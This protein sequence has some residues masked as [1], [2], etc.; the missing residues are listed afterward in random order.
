MVSYASGYKID[1]VNKKITQTGMIDIKTDP[2]D[3]DIFIDGEKKGI[4]R[5]TAKNLEPK[6]YYIKVE[7]NSYHSWSKKFELKGGEAV[8][9]NEVVL[10]K[11]N[12]KIEEFKS[13]ANVNTFI[14]LADTDN[15]TV[16]K[17]EIYQNGQLVT[18]LSDDIFGVCWYPNRY[19]IAFTSNNKLKIIEIDGT[20]L[21]DLLEKN[22]ITPI[23]FINSGHSIIFENQNKIYKAE[24]R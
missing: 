20:N 17:G 3:S 14:N 15:L 16:S 1:F 6:S 4:G 13:D 8:I 24:I 7:R 9:L 19:Y 12:P 22:S 21:I 18:R 11:T 5:V 2:P 23:I 10:F